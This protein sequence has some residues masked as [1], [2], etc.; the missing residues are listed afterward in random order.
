[1][2]IKESEFYPPLEIA[3]M[4][5]YALGKRATLN[6]HVDLYFVLKEEVA[7]LEQIIASGKRKYGR[8]WEFK[9]G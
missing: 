4:K 9:K 8:E 5:A 3:A 1:L 7:S 6:D 2:T